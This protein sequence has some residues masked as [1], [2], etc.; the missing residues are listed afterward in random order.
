M[1]CDTSSEGRRLNQFTFALCS[2][3]RLHCYCQRGENFFEFIILGSVSERPNASR[4][5]PEIDRLN[6]RSHDQEHVCRYGL[7]KVGCFRRGLSRL[8]LQIFRSLESL[9]TCKCEGS[10]TAI[11]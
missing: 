8:R 10:Q 3:G 4:N 7:P 2:L 5:V 9:G 11:N 1:D 6:F